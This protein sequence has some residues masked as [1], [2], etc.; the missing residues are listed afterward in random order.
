M[1]QC[2]GLQWC[3]QLPKAMTGLHLAR[4]PRRKA[5]HACLLYRAVCSEA[6]GLVRA[7]LALNKHCNSKHSNAC[8]L[9]SMLIVALK[10]LW[11]Q[12]D[13][14][15]LQNTT[16]LLEEPLRTMRKRGNVYM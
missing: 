4:S 5:A 12:P 8:M 16:Y 3:C 15:R 11:L 7:G 6:L 10:S 14:G 9:S 1:V 13:H 2:D